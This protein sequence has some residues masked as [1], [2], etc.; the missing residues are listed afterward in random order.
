MPYKDAARQRQYQREWRRQRREDFFKDKMC[1]DC[2]S[3]TRLQLDHRDR[4][5]KVSHCIWSWS[6]ARRN[7]E[8][9]KCDVRCKK[10][11]DQR[12]FKEFGYKE[13]SKRRYENDGCRCSICR[14]EHA[15][16]QREWRQ[17]KG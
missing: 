12:H 15:D 6:A 5:Q 17:R 13:H 16:Y 8:I 11:H 14:K 1:I 2:G 10:C 4:A 3:S 7:M 9:A